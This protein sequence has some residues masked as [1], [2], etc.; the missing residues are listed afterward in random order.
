MVLFTGKLAIWLTRVTNAKKMRSIIKINK[1]EMLVVPKKYCCSYPSRFQ[2]YFSNRRYFVLAKRCAVGNSGKTLLTKNLR[3]L[4]NEEKKQLANQFVIF[5]RHSGIIDFH[6]QNFYIKDKKWVLF[7]TEPMKL[8]LLSRV[9]SV[10]TSL[11]E[12]KV[13]YENVRQKFESIPE[14]KIIVEKC[15]KAK[16]KIQIEEL[17][18]ITQV[19]QTVALFALGISSLALL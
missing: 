12:A 8:T 7:D 1:L 14:A 11:T 3:K 19:I 15:V 5:L 17:F 16:K 4:D 6:F 18:T 9:F 10:S 13:N 2:G